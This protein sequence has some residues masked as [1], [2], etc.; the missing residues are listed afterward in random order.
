M[1]E[2]PRVGAMGSQPYSD[3]LGMGDPDDRTMP[4]IVCLACSTRW[5]NAE[6]FWADAREPAADAAA[7]DGAA[8][9]DGGAPGEPAA[10]DADSLP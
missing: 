8:Q 6:A 1:E 9:G 7:P 2:L 3:I 5:P 4:E 10:P